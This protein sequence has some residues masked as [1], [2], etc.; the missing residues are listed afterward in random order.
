VAWCAVRTRFP[1]LVY[2]MAEILMSVCPE[3][4]SR[5][6]RSAVSS[7]L[8]CLSC[9]VAPRS[10][11]RLGLV[12]TTAVDTYVGG[13]TCVGP[14][15]WVLGLPLEGEGLCVDEAFASVA[16]GYRLVTA[17]DSAKMLLLI[18][19]SLALN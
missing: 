10:R 2:L 8:S 3:S 6:F 1:F 9:V 16:L 15:P 19:V 7:E 14:L 18:S 17:L 13:V 12:F 11:I 5:P 4:S